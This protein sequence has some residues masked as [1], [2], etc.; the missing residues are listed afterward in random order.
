MSGIKKRSFVAVANKSCPY[1]TTFQPQ[2]LVRRVVDRLIRVA[3][4][5]GTCILRSG[6]SLDAHGKN[7]FDR[8]Q[9]GLALFNQK[10][11]GKWS[12]MK[13]NNDG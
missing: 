12:I 5:I 3:K 9:A 11:C 7:L 8:L 1:G 2:G 13:V 10:M 6:N 4:S